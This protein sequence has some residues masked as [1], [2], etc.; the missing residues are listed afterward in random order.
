[1]LYGKPSQLKVAYMTRIFP[2]LAV[3]DKRALQV[4]E[5]VAAY[6]ISRSTIYNLINGGKLR[7]IK[8]GKR[9]LIPADAAEALLNEGAATR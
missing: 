6:G 3:Q 1:V 2:E 4:N 7:T 5:V 9:R 8:V